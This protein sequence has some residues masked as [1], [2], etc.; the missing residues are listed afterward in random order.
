M[1]RENEP[2]WPPTWLMVV[3]SLAIAIHLFLAFF[4]TLNVPSGPWATPQGAMPALAPAFANTI[5]SSFA[6][7]YQSVL[8]SNSTFRFS[9]MRQEQLDL[10]FEALLKDDKGTVTR[11]IS[12]PDPTAPSSIQYRQ[13]LLAQQLGNDEPLPPQQSV[14]IAAPGEQLPTLRWWQQDGDRRYVLKQDNP[15]AVPR[16]QQFMQPS[17][18]Q[19]IVAKSYARF[20]A[21]HHAAP[22]VEIQRS[23]YDPI[24]P[25]VLINQDPPTADELRRFMSSYGE[26]NQ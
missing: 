8:R 1:Q 24:M 22:K 26:L 14:I 17:Q 19:M 4:M 23:W 3:G 2:A 16:N 10:T 5:G 15:N 9:S 7:P 20:L 25:M 18:A 13:K 12:Y 6:L 21:R 11:K